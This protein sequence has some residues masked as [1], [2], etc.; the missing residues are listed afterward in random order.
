MKILIGVDKGSYT[1]SAAGKTVTINDVVK[2]DIKQVLLITNLTTN[3]I[4]YSPVVSGKGGTISNNV[5]SLVYDTTLMNNSDNLQIFVHLND[6]L[7]VKYDSDN[8]SAF[9]NL[10][11]F[12]PVSL[13]ENSFSN[14]RS[15]PIWELI[16][17]TG[18]T[19][20]YFT[21]SSTLDLIV[22][23]TA[24]SRVLN[25]Q[26]GYNFY[27]PGHSQTI[28]LT[29]V[30]G[31]SQSGVTKRIGYYNDF[32]GLY[33]E[34]SN[35]VLYTCLRSSTSGSLLNNR[36]TQSTWNKDTM[37]GSYTTVNP[38]GIN[39]DTTKAQIFFID[40]QWLGV[41]RIRYGIVVDGNRYIIHEVKNANN[42]TTTYMGTPS[43]PIRY[44]ALLTSN[45][46]GTSTLKQICASVTSGEII[47]SARKFSASTGSVSR[48]IT[49][50]VR[51]SLISIRLAALSD[52]KINRALVIPTSI[53]ILITS[54]SQVFVEIIL[55]KSNLN[56]TNLGGSPTWVPVTNSVIERSVNG[57]TTTGGSV[58]SSGFVSST[59]RNT[60]ISLG[61]I[62][63]FLALNS[64][65]SQ[66]DY[67]HVVVTPIGANTT[68][69]GSINYTENR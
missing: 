49:S 28:L 52:G 19:A 66:S 16:T 57:T 41:G 21:Q 15:L 54:N 3:D 63:D 58:I 34:Q 61:G 47:E 4:I 32:D 26:H 48:T 37:D 59:S 40:F 18:G 53:D 55:Q 31:S 43:L 42:I 27:T 68:F 10:P 20:T 35:G 46:V 25:E 9:G 39:I 33:F 2:L 69:Y 24:G 56:E 50:G 44:E 62:D 60:E 30:L 45:I 8:L 23:P 22:G 64:S 36:F 65:G 7:T 17:A 13:F 29:G 5:I 38:S 67:L 11:T 51:N 12:S 1:F 14:N 6:D